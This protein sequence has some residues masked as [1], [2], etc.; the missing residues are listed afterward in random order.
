M[1]IGITPVAR[2]VIDRMRKTNTQG[3]ADFVSLRATY[4]AAWRR[5]SVEVRRWQS[6]QAEEQK[7]ATS[8]REAEAAAQAAEEQ[9]RQARNAF[10]DY[11]LSQAVRGSVLVGSR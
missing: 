9:Y 3:E 4:Q 6:L 8:L 5:F 7:D 11:L 2:F 1:K 10:A